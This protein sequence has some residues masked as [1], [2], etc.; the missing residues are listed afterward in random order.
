[1]Y[2]EIENWNPLYDWVRKKEKKQKKR[3]KIYSQCV[4]R[5]RFDPRERLLFWNDSGN[6]APRRSVARNL[7]AAHKAIKPIA[8]VCR[9]HA[10]AKHSNAAQRPLEGV[11]SLSLLKTILPITKNT[12]KNNEK[13]K[14]IQCH[15]HDSRVLEA[16]S[17]VF[18]KHFAYA[19]AEDDNVSKH[20]CSSAS[21]LRGFFFN[22]TSRAICFR[23]RSPWARFLLIC[24][25]FWRR[26]EFYIVQRRR[27]G[28]PL[29]WIAP[30]FS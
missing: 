15:L 19:T 28:R 1:M 17:S 7:W 6:A 2:P 14:A 24:L 30:A 25:R 26:P 23:A 9:S 10:N 22:P 4:S 16:A 12:K 5:H 27:P 29:E 11:A 8:K 3:Y 18:E 13:N 20:S 21:T